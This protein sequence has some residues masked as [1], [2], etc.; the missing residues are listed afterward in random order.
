MSVKY[1]VTGRQLAAARVL[2]GLSQAFIA[3]RAHVSLPTLR[4]MEASLGVP[5]A[6]ENN[7]EAVKRC[8][9]DVGIDFIFD[10]SGR[11]GVKVSES[12]VTQAPT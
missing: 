1:H 6:M 3:E 2:A 7:I 5:S 4:R 10:A 11:P 9:E 8:L 12:G